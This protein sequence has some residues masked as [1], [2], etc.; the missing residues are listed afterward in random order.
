MII[1]RDHNWAVRLSPQD[2]PLDTLSGLSLVGT[3][4]I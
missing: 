2:N 3:T 1:D 4:S